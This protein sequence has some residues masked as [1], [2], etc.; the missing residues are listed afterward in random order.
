VT[1]GDL[2]QAARRADPARLHALQAMRAERFALMDRLAQLPHDMV[3]FTQI[4][5]EAAED[6]EFLR[7]MERA[8]IRGRWSAWSR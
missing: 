8:R 7:A 4:T 6:P 3:F 2:A 1:L 5:T